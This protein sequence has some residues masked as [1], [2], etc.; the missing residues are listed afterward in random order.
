MS[1]GGRFLREP[2]VHFLVIGAILFGA[3][4][5]WSARQASDET[6]ILVSQDALQRLSTIWAAEAGREPT[7]DDVR[8]LL[9]EY[10]R[11]EVLYREAQ[12]LGLDEDDT[13]IRRRLAQKM[14]FLLSNDTQAPTFSEADLRQ[15]YEK[16]RENYRVPEKVNLVHVPYGFANDGGSRQ[17]EM[18]IA[19]LRLRGANPP[20]SETLGDPFMLSR[21]HVNMDQANLARLFGREFADAVFALPDGQWSDPLRSR[22]ADHLVK[23]TGRTEGG[24]PPFEEVVA[25]VRRR[26]TERFVRQRDAAALEDL[27][28]RYRVIIDD[29]VS[30]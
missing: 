14:G 1:R 5:F 3:H 26:E 2:L 15:S 24:I 20:P 23:I 11:E 27:M 29:G 22:L 19:A 8:G 13:I 25:E 28:Q 9:A 4:S 12:R 17:T 21:S 6:T 7:S 10:V 16:N 30:P 18:D